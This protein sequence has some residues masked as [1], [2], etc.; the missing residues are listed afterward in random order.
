[1]T[2]SKLTTKAEGRVSPG[3]GR[4]I[5]AISSIA[6]DEWIAEWSGEIFKETQLNALPPERHSNCVQIG[7]DLYLV[8]TEL[9]PADYVN[10][11]CAPNAGLHGDRILVALRDIRPGEEICYDYAMT[12]TSN[13][14]EFCAFVGRQIV[15]RGLLVKIGG[16]L[17]Y[18]TVIKDICPRTLRN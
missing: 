6:Q 7:G 14:D 4:G 17:S 8:P 15:E 12:D 1:M 3:K 2:L 16:F 5:F 11:S 18:V 13:Y 9:T 10:H